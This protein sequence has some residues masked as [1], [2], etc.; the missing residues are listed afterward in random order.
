MN[1]KRKNSN[2]GG[3]GLYLVFI[4]AI[5]VLWWTMGNDSQKTTMTK[6]E[7]VLVLEAQQVDAVQISQNTE[8]PT[9]R[10][11]VILKDGKKI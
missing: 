5:V 6:A 11:S 1:T 4:I 9:G 2:L 8:V 10:V 7:F 3:W